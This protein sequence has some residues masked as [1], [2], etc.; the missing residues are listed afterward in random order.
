MC[1]DFMEYSLT[2]T[3]SMHDVTM[4][5][6]KASGDLIMQQCGIF[7]LKS[8]RHWK[9]AIGKGT[10]E[11][12]SK[13]GEHLDWRDLE[14]DRELLHYIDRE[15]S[16]VVPT[17]ETFDDFIFSSRS[18]V[19]KRWCAF[20]APAYAEFVEFS[21]QKGHALVS[22]TPPALF[23]QHLP[24]GQERDL[25]LS[26]IPMQ[27]Y[28]QVQLRVEDHQLLVIGVTKDAERSDKWHYHIYCK[29]LEVPEPDPSAAALPD[30]VV[31]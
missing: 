8:L 20:E 22:F 25:F 24:Y 3:G 19:S 13:E 28:D 6:E 21:M 11:V 16:G 29:Q 31:S 27:Q 5:L 7:N 30:C 10:G 15:G 9:I 12:S 17:L 18:D 1:D 23:Y 26:A 4:W 2:L 14:R